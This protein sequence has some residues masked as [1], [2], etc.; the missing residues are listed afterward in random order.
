[1]PHKY[2]KNEYGEEDFTLDDLK[3]TQHALQRAKERHIPLEDLHR[4]NGKVGDAV[5]VGNTVVTVVPKR[6]IKPDNEVGE[7]V[8]TNP[9]VLKKENKFIGKLQCPHILIPC[10]IGNRRCRINKLSSFIRGKITWERDIDKFRIET[11]NLEDTIFMMDFIKFLIER[12]RDKD[13]ST[14]Y[15]F[16]KFVINKEELPEEDKIKLEQ[17]YKV[18]IGQREDA[19]YIVSR[20]ERK[21]LK[22]IEVLN[23]IKGL[24]NDDK[25]VYTKEEEYEGNDIDESE[26][27]EESIDYE[28]DDEEEIIDE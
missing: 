16:E 9:K 25:T 10:I 22:I 7:I 18:T 12:H 8:H 20:V 5:L 23:K 15:H 6:Q 24:E 13:I 28:N 14:R 3:I 1:M 4:L 21:L 11:D 19:V 17:D 2:F 27:L 26:F